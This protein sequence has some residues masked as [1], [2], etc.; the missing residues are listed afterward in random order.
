MTVVV[1][2]FDPSDNHPTIWFASPDEQTV[3]PA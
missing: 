1:D 3:V 2:S